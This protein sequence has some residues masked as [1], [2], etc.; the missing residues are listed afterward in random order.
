MNPP[1]EKTQDV[2]HVRHAFQFLK[3]G[4]V[5]AAVV[6]AGVTFRADA[7]YSAFREWI[8]DNGGILHELGAGSFTGADAFR[9]TGVNAYRLT[10]TAPGVLETIQHSEAPAAAQHCEEPAHIVTESPEVLTVDI[11]DAEPLEDRSTTTPPEPVKQ[12]ATTPDPFADEF[13]ALAFL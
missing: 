13:A 8:E 1:F 6:S 9:Q 12:P 4:G 10:I 5:L 7:V 2:A 11:L 3:P